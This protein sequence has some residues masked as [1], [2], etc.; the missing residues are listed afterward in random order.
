MSNAVA[1]FD[2]TQL[3]KVMEANSWTEGR[4]F[5][6]FWSDGTAKVAVVDPLKKK[7][8][9]GANLNQGLRIY[10]V[11]WTWLNSFSAV[12]TKYQEFLRQPI[13]S[14]AAKALLI[15]KYGSP[16]SKNIVTPF[17]DWLVDRLQPPQYL[18]QI[19]Q[20]QLQFM[21]VNP[22]ELNGG[23]FDDLVAALNGFNFFAFYKGW[24]VNGAAF[25][26]N[27]QVCAPAKPGAPVLPKPAGITCNKDPLARIDMAQ[28]GSVEQLL[29]NPSVRSVV[30]VTHVGV[31]AGDLYEFNGAQYLATWDIEN[32][33]VELSN[34]DYAWGNS[35]TDDPKDIAVTNETFNDYRKK[36]GRGGDFL[37]LSPIQLV[38]FSLTLPVY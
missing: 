3:F 35:D 38:P 17:N 10:T 22:F 20:H 26:T 28:R 30:C 11:Q 8:T 34:W 25:R 4:N 9:I 13:Q 29:K 21:P 12:H 5:M 1:H 18:Q 7:S 14:P 32:N 19:R 37:A 27:Q 16:N 31:Y 15:S 6:K 36:T 33:T 24:V 2:I 23:K